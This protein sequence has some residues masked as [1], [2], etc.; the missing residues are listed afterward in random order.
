MQ[1]LDAFFL[2]H[3][4]YCFIRYSNNPFN[5]NKETMYKYKSD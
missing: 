4:I 1:F 5:K 3:F 2:Y